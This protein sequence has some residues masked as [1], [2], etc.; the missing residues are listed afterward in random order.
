MRERQPTFVWRWMVLAA[1]AMVALAPVAA[2][3]AEAEA[4][5]GHAATPL[6]AAKGLH[7]TLLAIPARAPAPRFTLTKATVCL[8]AEGEIFT[9][10]NKSGSSCVTCLHCLFVLPFFFGCS[11][12][13]SFHFHSR[14]ES[15]LAP[16]FF[17][18]SSLILFF[19]FANHL[20]PFSIL[21]FYWLSSFYS[22]FCFVKNTLL[23][24]IYYCP[25]TFLCVSL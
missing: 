3:E 10:L 11:F 8:R 23:L 13:F 17:Y 4:R 19:F 6:V 25:L 1:P 22:L 24:N 9:S 18:F 15:G 7:V 20:F 2:V 5:A 21:S 14:D 12:L 16:S